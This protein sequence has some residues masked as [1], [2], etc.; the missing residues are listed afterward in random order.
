MAGGI[1]GISAGTRRTGIAV[2][3]NGTLVDWKVKEWKGRWSREKQK[4]ILDELQ[5]LL[6]YF[7][8]AAVVM[9]KPDRLRSSHQLNMLTKNI[10]RLVK[11]KRISIAQ[12]SLY[13]MQQYFC[14]GRKNVRQ[15]IAD[16]MVEKYP[17]LKTAYLRERNSDRGYYTRMFE[18]IAVGHMRVEK[19]S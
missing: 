17:F 16:C 2:F 18:A 6:D 3:A 4:R 5:E 10:S 15:G 9:K 11:R 8:P 7:G 19:D 14:K 12:Y 13:D 1:I